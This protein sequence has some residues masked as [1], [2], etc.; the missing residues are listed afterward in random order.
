[1]KSTHMVEPDTDEI[2]MRRHA[3]SNRIQALADNALA[4]VISY[5]LQVILTIAI[6]VVGW[7]LNTLLERLNSID[8]R[9]N[10]F[11]IER[12]TTELRLTIV[13]KRSIDLEQKVETQRARVQSIE[14]EQAIEAQLRGRK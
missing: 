2:P 6:T 13:E 9:L 14:T 5:V 1:M 8:S 4:K 3:D 7:S 12:A 10:A 11:S